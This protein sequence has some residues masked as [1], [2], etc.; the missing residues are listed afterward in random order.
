MG[1]AYLTGG[2]ELGLSVT[3]TIG[4]PLINIGRW[5]DFERRLTPPKTIDRLQLSDQTINELE[6]LIGYR[7]ADPDLLSQAVVRPALIPPEVGL[8]FG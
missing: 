7:F 4:L 5:S 8:T 6:T 2:Q 1:A 3:K